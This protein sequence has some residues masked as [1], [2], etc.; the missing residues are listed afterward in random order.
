MRKPILIQKLN[1][2]EEW[3]DVGPAHAMVNKASGNGKTYLS[4]G[5]EQSSGRKVF[6]VRYAKILEEIQ[7]NLQS[8]RIISDEYI[9]MLEDY[10]DFQ[11]EHIWI[12]LLGVSKGVKQSN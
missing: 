4:S 10:D 1:D 5:S 2:D 9:Y 7:F 12:H 3:K 8:Y 11:D 6:K